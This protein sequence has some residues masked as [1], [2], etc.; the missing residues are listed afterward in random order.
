MLIAPTAQIN[1]QIPA[2]LAPGLATITILNKNEV[3]ALGSLTLA[4]VAP[5]LFTA[6]ANGQGV[7]AAQLQ[8]RTANGADRFEP[9]A[10]YDETQKLFFRACWM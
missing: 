2:G 4:R 3:V 8:R 10:A 6:N 5:G 1:Y 7:A 9:V